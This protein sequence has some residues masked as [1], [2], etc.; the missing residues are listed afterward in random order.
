MY[1]GL[2]KASCVIIPR[3]DKCSSTTG[4]RTVVETSSATQK[5]HHSRRESCSSSNDKAK[6]PCDARRRA[7]LA[8]ADTYYAIG[9]PHAPGHLSSASFIRRLA[10][11]AAGLVP[12]PILPLV[13]ARIPPV[14]RP[15]PE[16]WLRPQAGWALAAHVIPLSP[17]VTGGCWLF[18]NCQTARPRGSDTS[19]DVFPQVA[20]SNDRSW[21][22]H[23]TAQA[24]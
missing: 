22:E 16:G 20:P 7:Q 5:L 4:T 18:A 2:S 13:C 9:P 15:S 10:D 14:T 23:S 8:L 1:F 19:L 21:M 3:L 17:D 6:T 11:A 12:R 24:W